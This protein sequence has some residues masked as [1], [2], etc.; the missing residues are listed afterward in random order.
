MAGAGAILPCTA[1][2]RGGGGPAGRPFGRPLGRWRGR[3]RFHDRNQPLALR[4][5]RPRVAAGETTGGD[6]TVGAVELAHDPHHEGDR[7]QVLGGHR[8]IGHEQRLVEPAGLQ[9]SVFLRRGGHAA[10]EDLLDERVHALL[11]H[12][13]ALSDLDDRQ[14][15][16]EGIDDQ[17]LALEPHPAS[18]APRPERSFAGIFGGMK[19]YGTVHAADLLSMLS[20]AARMEQNKNN[21]NQKS[22]LATSS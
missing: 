20:L 13:E 16:V 7:L 22:G 9:R 10:G 12:A 6:K 5:D 8:A 19:G 15:A 1:K 17:P 4:F 2:R 14:A 21:V 18:G 3:R 11:R